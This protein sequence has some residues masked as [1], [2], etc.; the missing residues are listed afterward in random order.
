MLPFTGQSAELVHD[1]PAAADLVA[2]LVADAERVL[3]RAAAP[4]GAAD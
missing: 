2:R 1:I 4:S 3:H